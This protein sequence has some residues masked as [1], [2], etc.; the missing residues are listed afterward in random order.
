MEPII[1]CIIIVRRITGGSSNVPLHPQR[2]IL[3]QEK[4][5]VQSV[6][7]EYFWEKRKQKHSMQVV[8][9]YSFTSEVTSPRVLFPVGGTILQERYREIESPEESNND[10]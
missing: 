5:K 10:D 4:C 9:S 7:T 6:E 8:R 2:C 3:A 1:S